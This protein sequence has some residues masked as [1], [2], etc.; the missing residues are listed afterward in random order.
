M[1]GRD[2]TLLPLLNLPGPEIILGKHQNEAEQQQYGRKRKDDVQF[3]RIEESL[4]GSSH[5]NL[6]MSYSC[7]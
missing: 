7:S 5:G 3:L 2:V 4:S 6:L 1:H